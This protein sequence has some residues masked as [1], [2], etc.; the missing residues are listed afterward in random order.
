MAAPLWAGRLLKN[1][2]VLR[3]NVGMLDAFCKEWVRVNR[4][5]VRLEGFYV[6]LR[7]MDACAGEMVVVVINSSFCATAICMWKGEVGT[8]KL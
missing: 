8:K 4:P 1:C 7:R 3:C 5:G 2:V 6:R